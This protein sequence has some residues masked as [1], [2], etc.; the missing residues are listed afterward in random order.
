MGRRGQ[1]AELAPSYVFLA[2]HADSSIL[3]VKSFMSMVAILSHLNKIN[4]ATW[5]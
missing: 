1:P 2:T 4:S 5:S 3:L